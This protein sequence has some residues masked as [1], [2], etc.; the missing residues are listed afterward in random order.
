MSSS[1]ITQNPHV[2]RGSFLDFYLNEAEGSHEPQVVLEILDK[3]GEWIPLERDPA[4]AE[5]DSDLMYDHGWADYRKEV[6]RRLT[7][8]D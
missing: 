8:E 1:D 7:N 4:Y 2:S 6:L 5:D 3:L